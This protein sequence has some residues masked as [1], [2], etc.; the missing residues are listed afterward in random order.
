MVTPV[1]AGVPVGQILPR[2]KSDFL[3]RY[4]YFFRVLLRIPVSYI[5]PNAYFL[6]N[7]YSDALSLWNIIYS[8]FEVLQKG[9]IRDILGRI[10]SIP[11]VECGGQKGCVWWR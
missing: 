8:E 11:S 7:G 10:R 3:S 6:S 9:G 4:V 1:W 5:S 2:R